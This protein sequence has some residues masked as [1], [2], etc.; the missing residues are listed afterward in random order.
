MGGG[1]RLLFPN[2]LL[3]FPSGLWMV[4]VISEWTLDGCCYFLVDSEWLLLFHDALWMVVVSSWWTL[5]GCRY[6]LML[7]G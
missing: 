7:F 3:L 2:A 5:D 4:A 1:G 6:F